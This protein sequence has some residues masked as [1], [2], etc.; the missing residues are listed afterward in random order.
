MKTKILLL[1]IAMGLSLS[2]SANIIRDSVVMGASYTNDVFYKLSNR[3]KNVQSNLNYHIAFSNMISQDDR[4]YATWI[5]PEMVR[6]YVCTNYTVT[7]FAN[8]K[9]DATWRDLH[10]SDTSWGK[11]AFSQGKEVH[12]RYTWATYSGNG[13]LRGDSIYKIQIKDTATGNYDT[14]IK[15]WLK[16][17]LSDNGN[18]TWT[19]QYGKMDNSWDTTIVLNDL[20]NS[21]G[22]FM[23]YDFI[24]HKEVS[25]EPATSDWDLVFT[26]YNTLSQGIPYNVT[27]VLSN[28]NIETSFV[29]KDIQDVVLDDVQGLTWNKNINSIG[30]DW[31]IFN[32]MTFRF[33]LEQ[34]KTRIVSVP[35]AS[36]TDYYA[37]QFVDFQ[38][39]SNGKTVFD[40][41]FLGSV[42][43]TTSVVPLGFKLYPNPS[44]G[45]I[46]IDH[47]VKI[48]NLKIINTQGQ[49]VS[50][51]SNISKSL[52]ISWLTTGIY[53][54]QFT[55]EKNRTWQTRISK[56]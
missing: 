25:R 30:Y 21:Q 20:V 48:S 49:V 19:I 5:N 12:P 46:H 28:V 24:K 8:L 51:L 34:N 13:D 23:Y 55:D 9:N 22:N 45:T 14:E 39:Q 7:D 2:N 56:I 54:V 33:E 1:S 18:R 10:N 32:R 36:G 31:K 43:S 17:R 6:A 52:D 11:G 41:K 27:G 50:N 4:F 42:S 47:E 15:I 44:Q 37:I 26:R 38:G 16:Q 53:F 40:Y 3:T 29:E 35:T